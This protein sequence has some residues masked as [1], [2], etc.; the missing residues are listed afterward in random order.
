MKSRI[1]K[2]FALSTCG[3][4][5][6]GI[7][8][9]APLQPAASEDA[10]AG[11]VAKQT[12]PANPAET[13][14]PAAPEVNAEAA[15]KAQADA[16]YTDAEIKNFVEAAK[17]VD[18]VKLKYEGKLSTAKGQTEI[19]KIKKE[20]DAELSKTVEAK[21]LSVEKYNKIHQTALQDPQLLARIQKYM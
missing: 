3:L 12:A 6:T 7:A 8:M 16:N 17:N 18:Q 4:M 14:T 10:Q 9:A 13:A 11:E 15:T 20:A 1:Y 19:D 21:G 2:T 5:L